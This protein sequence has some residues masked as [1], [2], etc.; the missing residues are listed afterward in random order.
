MKTKHTIGQSL[1]GL[2][3]ML[4]M[5]MIVNGT[6]LPVLAQEQPARPKIVKEIISLPIYPELS[7]TDVQVIIETI[8]NFTA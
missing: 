2:V 6:V 8:R 3:I 1:S 5:G 4:I 7:E